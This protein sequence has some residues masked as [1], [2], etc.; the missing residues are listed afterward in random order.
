MD[1][2]Q[3]IRPRQTLHQR[4]GCPG[5]RP[6]RKFP[7]SQLGRRGF[8]PKSR[9]RHLGC[10]PKLADRDG[11]QSEK[12]MIK[13]AMAKIT[14]SK[15][16]A[17]PADADKTASASADVILMISGEMTVLIVDGRLGR[18]LCGR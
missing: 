9:P 6:D 18:T 2:K 16:D 5:P 3:V 8:S 14:P 11:I 4:W 15:C 7:R 13:L 12:N 1:S 10:S 17:V